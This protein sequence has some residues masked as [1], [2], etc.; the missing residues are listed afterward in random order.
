[1]NLYSHLKE[2]QKNVVDKNL[3][4][5][6]EVLNQ[7]KP[8]YGRQVT[9]SPTGSGKTFI[10]AALI[11][12]GLK[13]FP[14]INF[15]WLTHNKQ[16]LIQT[17]NEIRKSL[18]NIVT[19]VYDI[20]H[21]INS[22]MGK[23]LLFNVQ[24]GISKKSLHWLKKWKSFQDLDRRRSILIIDEADEGM[25]GKNMDSLTQV[26]SPILELGFTASFKKKNN[27]YEYINV[28]YKDVIEANMLVKEI[29]YEA[30]DEISRKEIIRRAINQRQFLEEK[31]NLL[32]EFDKDR[33]FIPKMLIQAPAKDCE[34]MARE[35]NSF[36]QLNDQDFLTQVVIHTQNSRGL[37]E[38]EDISEVR[39]IIGDLM[40]ERGWNCP[41]A[42]VLL[43]TK[44]S[45]SKSKGIQLLGRV[46][47]LP[48]S[49]PFDED[50]DELN[51]GYVYISGKH[52]IEE[53]C[54]NFIH[55][56][57]VL[58]PPKEVLQI[59]IQKNIIIPSIKTF[60]DRLEKNIE[61]DSLIGTSELICESI[62]ELSKNCA[63]QLP[64][65]RQGKLKLD[66]EVS[67]N[68]E[69]NR[70]GQVEWNV[71]MAKKC[72]IDALTYH[73]PRNYASLI[74]TKYQ[75]K[76]RESGGLERVAPSAKY[77]AKL[78]RESKNI[79]D[80][81]SKLSYKYEAYKWP[82]FKLILAYPHPQEFKNSLYPKV[83]LNSEELDF[84]KILEKICIN[85]N[86]NWVRND[87]SNIKIF[88]GHCPD[89]IVFNEYK[90]VFI[91]FKGKHLLFSDDTKYKN[92]KGQMTCPYLLVYAE[93]DT[94][95]HMVKGLD[96]QIDQPFNELLIKITLT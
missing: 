37:D 9:I 2:F 19:T 41:E 17:Q 90:F 72:L 25:S 27:E 48:K 34:D 12:A 56:L 45:I 74:I 16:I 23:V 53:S 5:I 84:A 65:V 7:N 22:F 38:L 55:E 52:S 89:F 20:E 29:F 1:M 92:L 93:K 42:Y 60:T 46:I 18:G 76:L 51:R 78:I 70:V 95:V 58:S 43:S 59:E 79:R 39:Y 91:E 6:D 49:I 28:S 82:P 31:A 68:S 3:L 35:L 4:L 24:K 50:F 86:F 54:K 21:E 33:F 30:S 26:L 75:I 66:K 81:S 11:E 8:I 36:L 87:I 32:K 63:T 71:E 57:P 85:N 96:G 77:L 47:R 64:I 14:S 83:Q 13:N 15:I 69:M 40:V 94:G 44:E 61:D 10:M 88:K 62:E 67:V 80:I 73:L